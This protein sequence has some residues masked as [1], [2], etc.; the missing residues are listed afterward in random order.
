LTPVT[1]SSDQGPASGSSRPAAALLLVALLVLPLLAIPLGVAALVSSTAAV[2]TALAA[3]TSPTESVP[4]A[5]VTPPSTPAART[6]PTD[7][8]GQPGFALP[9][10]GQPRRASLTNPPAPIPERVRA[11]YV[12]AAAKYVLP[13]T[14]LAGI[15]MAETGHGRT[16]IP[17]SAGALG[18][19][20]FLPATFA[21]VGIDGNGDGRADIG[22][23]ADSVFSAANYLTISGVTRGP[24]GV[25]QA[26][27]AYNHADWY[28]NDVLHYAHAYGGGTVPGDPTTCGT[29]LG[30]GNPD[31]PPLDDDRIATLLAWAAGH[32][33]EPYV[34]GAAGPHAWDCSSFTRAAYAT[35]GITLPR[36]ARAQR[37]WLA[38]GH[39]HRVP[40]GQ[41]R[42]GDLVFI[43][44]YLG[45]NTIGHVM[46]VWN[47]TTHTTIEAKSTR[48]GVGHFTY[49]PTGHS[50]FE[51]W[52][53]GKITDVT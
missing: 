50:I 1:V 2:Q 22:D 53:G 29:G 16:S 14:L 3:C 35:A 36:T 6:T 32:V 27:Y 37:D 9:L 5:A 38:A 41:E 18:L 46:L 45:P 39:G 31:P 52:R 40:Y 10:P 23:D 42:P 26:L 28:V 24:G 30:D 20:Q 15:G 47:P 21:K 48:S 7:G 49:T 17:S 19:M 4:A 34:Y 11:L 51:I 33:G 12:A 43:D 8:E 44:S 25:R 13:W